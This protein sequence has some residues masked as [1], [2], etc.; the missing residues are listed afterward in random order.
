MA[1]SELGV[2]STQCLDNRISDQ[3]ISSKEIAAWQMDRNNH[4]AKADRQFT[5]DDARVKLK[6]L[7][8]TF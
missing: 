3:K 6:H 7:Y 4:H 5:T 1:E 8:S 2:L